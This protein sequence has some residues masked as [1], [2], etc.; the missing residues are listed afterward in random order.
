M[1]TWYQ[2]EQIQKFLSEQTQVKEE[3]AAKKCLIKANWNVEEAVRRLG[4]ESTEEVK[5]VIQ[6]QT[7]GNQV[8]TRGSISTTEIYN[9]WNNLFS[10]QTQTKLLLTLLFQLFFMWL[11]FGFVF[12][13]C[14]AL[15]WIVESMRSN[16]QVRL[17]GQASAY[18]AFNP[19]CQPLAGS[20]E[21][22]SR[23]FFN[24]LRF[25]S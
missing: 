8:G 11:E 19:G 13:I 2:K 22:S 23:Q 15:F 18:A 21:E 9:Y 4:G 16:R 3:K 6:N 12:F 10:K 24:A 17:P 25:N 1:G 5:E 14:A 20:F 7:I